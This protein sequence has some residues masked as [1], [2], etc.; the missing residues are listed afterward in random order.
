MKL[1]VISSGSSGNC[2]CIN[3]NGHL[4]FVDAGVSLTAVKK[5][6]CSIESPKSVSLFVTHEHQDHISGIIPFIKYYNPKVYTSRSDLGERERE[7]ER[8]GRKETR[9][10][11]RFPTG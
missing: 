9:L 7:R 11:S 6:L 1:H 3:N 2:Y 5:A 8:G 4:I 10:G